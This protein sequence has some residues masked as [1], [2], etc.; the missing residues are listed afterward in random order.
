[1]VDPILYVLCT[2]IYILANLLIANVHVPAVVAPGGF[3]GFLETGR[4][5][6]KAL[7]MLSKAAISWSQLAAR[8]LCVH[9]SV[10]TITINCIVAE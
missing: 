8:R 5:S 4:P 6:Q 7:A 9:T 3:L 2:Y 10:T 1:M